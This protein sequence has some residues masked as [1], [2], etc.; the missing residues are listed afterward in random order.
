MPYIRT[1][2]SWKKK[3][4]SLAYVL[5]FLMMSPFVVHD[6]GAGRFSLKKKTG[7][8]ILVLFGW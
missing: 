7:C 8:T 4:S 3:K 5:F 6:T 2:R 1:T